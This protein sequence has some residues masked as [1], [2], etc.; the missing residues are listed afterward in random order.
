MNKILV[1]I[2]KGNICRNAKTRQI[3]NFKGENPSEYE[4]VVMTALEFEKLNLDIEVALKFKSKSFK[5]QKK[6]VN[7]YF[8]GYALVR[9]NREDIII[10]HFHEL[11]QV[12]D[13]SFFINYQEEKIMRE[14]RR[15]NR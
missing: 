11:E 12:L 1:P 15:A 3:E 13:G 5:L 4:G 9:P 8:R 2:A 6:L 7:G 14:R 10:L